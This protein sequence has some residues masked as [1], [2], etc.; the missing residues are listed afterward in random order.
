[1]TSLALLKA[2]SDLSDEWDAAPDDPG[3]VYAQRLRNTV[4]DALARSAE[5]CS[6][7]QIRN[8]LV[9][10]RDQAH[11]YMNLSAE[12]VEAKLAEKYSIP[13]T[14]RCAVYDGEDYPR[15]IYRPVDFCLEGESSAIFETLRH[16]LN[17]D[18][19]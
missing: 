4:T 15:Q 13:R 11:D 5:R 1:M 6:A 19:T 2:L 17:R 7:V 14:V 8:V 9:I 16:L 12:E 10:A 18:A 3:A